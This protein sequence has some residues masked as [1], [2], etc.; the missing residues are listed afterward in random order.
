MNTLGCR[1]TIVKKQIHTN[2]NSVFGPSITGLLTAMIACVL[3]WKARQKLYGSYSS[4]DQSDKDSDI[5]EDDV[6]TEM[7]VATF[8]QCN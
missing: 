5:V 2:S 1:S 8:E 3:I 4:I 7:E 6:E